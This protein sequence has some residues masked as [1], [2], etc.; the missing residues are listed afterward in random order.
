MISVNTNIY[1]QFT[2]NATRL[3]QIEYEEKV[4]R[5]TN[6]CKL[7]RGAD[8][9]SGL[10]ISTGMRG[11]ISGIDVA[12]G[13]A[14]ETTDMLQLVDDFADGLWDVLYHMRN[15]SVELANEAVKSN[16]P[17][18][19]VADLQFHDCMVLHKEIELLKDHVY[20]NFAARDPVTGIDYGSVA[21]WNFNGK[22]IFESTGTKG[23]E[24]P[25]GLPTQV[26][27]NN[28]TAHQIDIEFD[29]LKQH[30]PYFSTPYT[31]P[32][33]GFEPPGDAPISYYRTYAQ[34]TMD[35]MTEIMDDTMNLRAQVGTQIQRLHHTI[36]DL[37]AEYN[38]TANAKSL[39]TDADMADEITE[40]T[41]NMIKQQSTN[42]TYTQA[43]AQPLITV[44]LLEAIYDGLN[45]KTVG[46]TQIKQAG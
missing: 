20:M 37:T 5:L 40:L 11:Q 31:P 30:Y 18:S 25:P 22:P 26:G 27:A 2:H 39:I 17:G 36:D 4:E 35:K 24:I 19:S 33:A 9:P 15:L 14:Q 32:P 44:P 10:A 7:N 42:I 34:Q 29:S 8:D 41:A 13:N 23:F 16:H 38:F 6:G 1:A 28:W 43:N 21:K 46:D 45:E 3:N 12:I